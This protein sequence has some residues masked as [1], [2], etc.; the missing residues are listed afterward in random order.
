MAAPGNTYCPYPL[1]VRRQSLCAPPHV[2]FDREYI[3]TIIIHVYY[4]VPVL[5]IQFYL[6]DNFHSLIGTCTLGQFFG[7]LT[8]PDH[9]P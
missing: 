5:L 4:L 8:N 2:V 3:M 7:T 6:D 1:A 9:L